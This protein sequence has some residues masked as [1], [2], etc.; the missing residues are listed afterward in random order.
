MKKIEYGFVKGDINAIDPMLQF[1]DIP[2]G[3]IVKFT[4]EWDK[5]ENNW[6]PTNVAEYL[7]ERMRKDGETNT[8]I[9]SE[10]ANK[11]AD[12]ERYEC[13]NI[14]STE[15]EEWPSSGNVYAV[16]NRLRCAIRRRTNENARY[17][18]IEE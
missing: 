13:D 4:I 1:K 3:A 6:T 15:M 9:R 17:P 18:R 5:P 11:V 2:E 8:Q 12:L 7:Y 16:L 14:L 10:I